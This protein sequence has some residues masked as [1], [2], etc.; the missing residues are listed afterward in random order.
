MTPPRDW[1]PEPE[2]WHVP[3][4]APRRRF[5]RVFAM[6]W[7]FAGAFLYALVVVGRMG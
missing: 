5:W 4:A 3:E 6:G 2:P 1:S 7:L